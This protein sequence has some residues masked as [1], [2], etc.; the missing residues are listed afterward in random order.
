MTLDESFLQSISQMFP[1]IEE[2]RIDGC[3]FEGPIIRI[4]LGGLEH[5][6]RIELDP[7]QIYRKESVLLQ[8][9]WN[10]MEL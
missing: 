7:K 10:T 5:L 2:V 1:K 4:D 9:T 6:R 3:N 8:F